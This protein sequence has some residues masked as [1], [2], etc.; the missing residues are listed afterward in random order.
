MG[1]PRGMGY[2]MNF[3][4]IDELAELRVMNTR[5]F[6]SN[7]CGDPFQSG[8]RGWA[9]NTFDTEAGLLKQLMA[10]W[11]GSEENC[12]GYLTTGGSFAI[13]LR[14]ISEASY[15]LDENCHLV[16]FDGSALIL[17]E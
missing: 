14:S 17:V 7:N 8:E 6:I 15:F 10:P 1:G 2:P 5:N 9:S 11:G 12:W 16:L 13:L 3:H 4:R